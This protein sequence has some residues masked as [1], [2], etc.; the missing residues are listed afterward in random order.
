MT[1]PSTRVLVVNEN[2]DDFGFLLNLFFQIPNRS[3]QT[4]NVSTAQEGLEALRRQEHDVILVDFKPGSDF[5]FDFL[6]QAI[7]KEKSQ[8]PIIILSGLEGHDLD[9]E[10]M[11]LGAA[12][13]LN[14][15][16]L[17]PDILERSIRYALERKRPRKPSSDWRPLWNPART[18]F[19]QPPWTGSS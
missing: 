15:N 16:K 19:T 7:Q 17:D 1:G 11:N 18:P 13:F 6:R 9:L 4:D 2:P 14:K 5:G 3:Y 10:S 8:V 12:D